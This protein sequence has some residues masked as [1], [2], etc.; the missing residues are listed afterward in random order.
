MKHQ[1]SIPDVILMRKYYPHK[2]KRRRRK[3]WKLERMP[4]IREDWGNKKTEKSEALDMEELRDEIEQ[5]KAFRKNINIYADED[6][7]KEVEDM[8]KLGIKEDD[9]SSVSDDPEMVQLAEM[10]RKMDLR[11][12][13]K[14]TEKEQM[15]DMIAEMSKID[16]NIE[17]KP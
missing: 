13:T 4:I 5:N 9:E 17:D 6:G 10:I 12:Q 11:E 16:Q 14:D 3:M 2:L 1:S 8:K 7:I 15:N